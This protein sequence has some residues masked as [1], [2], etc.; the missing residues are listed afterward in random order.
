M[1]A[2][3][4]RKAGVEIVTKLSF[5]LAAMFAVLLT[6]VEAKTTSGLN[7]ACL[8]ASQ[9]I[10]AVCGAFDGRKNGM[11]LAQAECYKR[12]AAKAQAICGMKDGKIVDR[13][14]FGTLQAPSLDYK[15]TR[16]H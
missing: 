5:V 2:S 15:S 12:E 1:D 10:P 7:P 8:A 11:S 14:K 9:H 3:S 16:H 4:L 6:P 13:K